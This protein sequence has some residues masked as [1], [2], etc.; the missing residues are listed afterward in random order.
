MPRIQQ[1]ADMANASLLLF[2]QKLFSQP[3]WLRIN[4]YLSPASMLVYHRLKEDTKWRGEAIPEL[5]ATSLWGLSLMRGL[6]ARNQVFYMQ[7]HL[8]FCFRRARL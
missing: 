5:D 4:Q 1:L 2:R 3:Q 6:D 7:Q 8:L